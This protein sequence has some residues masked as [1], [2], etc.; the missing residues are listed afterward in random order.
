MLRNARHSSLLTPS[1]SLHIK[2]AALRP[3]PKLGLRP[4]PKTMASGG[5]ATQGPKFSISEGAPALRGWV[6]GFVHPVGLAHRPAEDA[7][8]H[9]Q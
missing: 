6:G 2:A 1:P 9:G 7:S 3:V 5:G 4:V 8:P